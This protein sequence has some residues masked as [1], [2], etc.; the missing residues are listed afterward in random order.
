MISE[1]TEHYAARLPLPQRP[2]TEQLRSLPMSVYV[3][4]AADSSMHDSAAATQV[5][6][7][8][9][10][11]L[12]IRNWPGAT[13]SLPMEYPERLNRELLGF[14]AAHDPT[15]ARPRTR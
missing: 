15:D 3:A 9:V 1:A 10:R 13:H 11:N 6:R 4:M 7:N 12:Q 5:A 2:S 14:V 8:N